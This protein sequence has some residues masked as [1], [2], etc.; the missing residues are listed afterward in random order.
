MK[1][2]KFIL[3]MIGWKLI[4]T[5]LPKNN[6]VIIG[7]PHTTNWDFP[8]VMLCLSGLGLKFSWVAKHS[9]F[10][11]PLGF[12]FRAIGGIA[13]NRSKRK[14]FMNTIKHEFETKENFMLAIAPEGTRSYTDHWKFG[15]YQIALEAKADVALGVVNY[16]KK[17]IGLAGHIKLSGDIEKDFEQIAKFYN[18]NGRGLYPEKASKIAIRDSE[19][20]IYKRQASRNNAKKD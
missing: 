9:L 7:A 19:L 18:E 20:R 15:F 2:S 4:E 14:E 16:E 3:R 13:V 11:P 12:L 10:R 17:E 5:E 8:L 6:Y 1:I